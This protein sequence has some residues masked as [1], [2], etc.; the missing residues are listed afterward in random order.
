M[1]DG[2]HSMSV[3]SFLTFS[4]MHSIWLALVWALLLQCSSDQ[5]LTAAAPSVGLVRRDGGGTRSATWVPILVVVLAVAALVLYLALRRRQ[6]QRLA[7]RAAPLARSARDR[8]IGRRGSEPQVREVT[9]EQLTGVRAPAATANQTGQTNTSATPGTNGGTTGAPRRTRRPG[10]TPSQMST[11]SLPQYMKEPGEDELVIYQG[12][13]ETDDVTDADGPEGGHARIT[14]ARISIHTTQSEMPLLRSE[15]NDS[16]NTNLLTANRDSAAARTSLETIDDSMENNAV[17]VQNRSSVDISELPPTYDVS[18]SQL[19][20][21]NAAAATSMPNV[22]EGVAVMDSSPHEPATGMRRGL[23]GLFNAMSNPTS[24]GQ[25][26]SAPAVPQAPDDTRQSRISHTHNRDNSGYSVGTIGSGSSH[27][28]SNSHDGAR[29]ARRTHR[30]SQSGN[31]SLFGLGSSAFRTVSRQRSSNTLNSVHLNSPSTISL[32]SISA[33]LSHTLTRTEIVYPRSGPTPEQL[34]LIS[35]RESLGRFGVPYG[36]DAIAY[37]ASSSRLNL[38]IP[39]PDFDA[40]VAATSRPRTGDS[41]RSQ[42]EMVRPSTGQSHSQTES[43]DSTTS[44]E[45]SPQDRTDTPADTRDAIEGTPAQEPEAPKPE[46]DVHEAGRSQEVA[47]SITAE[48]ETPRNTVIGLVGPSNG[49][50]A[51]AA[52]PSSFKPVQ[53]FR[54]VSRASTMQSFATAEESMPTTPSTEV[55]VDVEPPTPSASSPA[56]SEPSTP[57]LA[58]AHMQEPT[59]ATI[60]PVVAQTAVH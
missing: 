56:A 15:S 4:T 32:H 23:R 41:S 21:S 25:S 8:A 43:P 19:N 22:P 16:S 14:S 47:S 57:R 5:C 34:K 59:D 36:P 31:S 9:A 17:P 13:P 12:T 39:P 54:A 50:T 38:S 49:Q 51:S 46:A 1:K 2:L 55:F 60:M 58:P 40:S 48:T 33:P 29:S 10:R 35:S 6:L 18:S 20:V 42:G 45:P 30:P 3:I 53:E 11:K 27:S 26:A 52:P 44:L 28:H 24:R 7:D 37:A